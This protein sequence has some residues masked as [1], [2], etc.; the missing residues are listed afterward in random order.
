[1]AVSEAF[2][3][4][5]ASTVGA[6]TLER[7]AQRVDVGAFEMSKVAQEGPEHNCGVE[8]VTRRG[9]GRWRRHTA[10]K[11]HR[12]RMVIDRRGRPSREADGQPHCIA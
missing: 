4:V 12:G 2:G 3:K 1:M 7:S 11:A 10:S 9:E 5:H 8:T 6:D